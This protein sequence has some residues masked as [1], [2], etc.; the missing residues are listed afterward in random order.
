MLTW[1]AF[2]KYFYFSHLVCDKQILNQ[3]KLIFFAK[4]HTHAH[5]YAHTHTHTHTQGIEMLTNGCCCCYVKSLT[6]P[7]AK[8]GTLVGRAV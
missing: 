6:I 1:F 5:I 7:L 3:G 4:S 2:Q 8:H